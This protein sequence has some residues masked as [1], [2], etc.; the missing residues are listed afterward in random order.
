MTLMRILTPWGIA[1]VELQTPEGRSMVGQYW[2]A[3]QRF[4]ATGETEPLEPFR[5]TLIRD[6]LLLTDPDEIERLARL[7][8]LDIDDIY[9]E[10][11]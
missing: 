10:P 8:E 5:W 9:L 11:R 2:N 4:L 1:D 3:V 6:R 7:G